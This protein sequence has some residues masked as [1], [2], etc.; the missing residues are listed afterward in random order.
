MIQVD[1]SGEKREERKSETTTNLILQLIRGGGG[2]VGR[3][4]GSDLRRFNFCY[5]PSLSIGV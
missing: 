4:V 1:W 5:P 3:G 2:G